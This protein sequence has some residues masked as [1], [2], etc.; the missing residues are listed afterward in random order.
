MSVG[1]IL[2]LAL[3]AGSVLASAG[4][5][6]GHTL[7]S[8][9]GGT[10]SA[11]AADSAPNRWENISSGEFGGLPPRWGMA[12]AWDPSGNLDL[13]YGGGGAGGTIHN[14]TWITDDATIR[15]ISDSSGSRSPPPLV[16]ASLAYDA[17]DAY[18]VLF[19]GETA[20]GHL[21]S[22]TWTFSSGGPEW[23][24]ITGSAGAAP[25]AQAFAPMA[26]DG[27][28]GYVVLESS[29]GPHLTWE[30]QSG[31]WNLSVSPDPPARMGASLTEDP[32]VA[33]LILFGGATVGG[34]TNETWAYAAGAWQD[35]SLPHSPPAEINGSTAFDPVS[36][37]LLQFGGSDSSAMWG[38]NGTDWSLLPVAGSGGPSPR[39][40]AQ[41]QYD[42][43]GPFV[44]VFGGLPVR[45]GPPLGDFW[46]WN[47]PVPSSDPTN[48]SASFPPWVIEVGLAAI[49]VPVGLAI[50]LY[51]PPGRKPSEAPAPT[52]RPVPAPA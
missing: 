27:R 1:S 23:S 19:G 25:P 29:T 4:V 48:A 44:T 35:L 17:A 49:V 52:R 36:G 39:V 2:L 22:S 12:E 32:Q 38:F 26:Y 10:L 3:V 11:R 16:G 37:L 15:N 21:S 9:R 42:D 14:D 46:A 13:Y 45:G 5:G 40:Y 34:A 24:N 20:P 7:P 51:R 50:L 6:V 8:G 31:K 47:P 28:D 33:S 18:F 30:F 41:M 43:Q